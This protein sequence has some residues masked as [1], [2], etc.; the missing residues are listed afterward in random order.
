M[1]S[2]GFPRLLVLHGKESFEEV[3][4]LIVMYRMCVL[5][6]KSGYVIS[7]YRLDLPAKRP[8]PVGDKDMQVK[9]E[10]FFLGS[11]TSGSVRVRD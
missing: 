2:L 6:S 11:Y 8:L 4:E 5:F 10:N 1:Y 9:S 3:L 7:D